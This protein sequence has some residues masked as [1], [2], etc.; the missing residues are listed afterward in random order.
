MVNRQDL[1]AGLFFVAIGL[2]FGLT[3]YF[4]LKIG[5]GNRMGPGYFPVMLSIAMVILG[6]LITVKAIG[7]DTPATGTIPWRGALLILACPLIFGATVQG[8]G[9][10]PALAISVFIASFASQ[11][12]TPLLALALTFGLTAFCVLVFHFGLGSPIRLYGPWI[13]P[14]L[15]W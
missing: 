10:V 11:R 8:L 13:S 6:A 4:D 2:F 14:W 15:G 5:T 7:K 3:A 9:L 12:M 1:V